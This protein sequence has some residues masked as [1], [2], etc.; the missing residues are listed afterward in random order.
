MDYCTDCVLFRSPSNWQKQIIA[1]ESH[2]YNTHGCLIMFLFTPWWI[3]INLLVVLGPM[4]INRAQEII[5]NVHL[6][7]HY[8]FIRSYWCLDGTGWLGIDSHHMKFDQS[9]LGKTLWGWI[10]PPKA[11]RESLLKPSLRTCHLSQPNKTS[12]EIKAMTLQVS[13]YSVLNSSRPNIPHQWTTS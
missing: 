6:F 8:P 9:P 2:T 7:H 5:P 13:R 11:F 12:R 1:Y 3:S 10:G 4:A